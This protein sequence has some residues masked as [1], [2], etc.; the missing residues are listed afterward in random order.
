MDDKAFKANLG[1]RLLAI[2]EMLK[3]SQRKFAALLGVAKSTYKRYERDEAL[4]DLKFLALVCSKCSV[5]AAWLLLGEGRMQGDADPLRSRVVY[6]DTVIYL[7]TDLLRQ[8][9]IK[10]QADPDNILKVA[11][12]RFE[13]EQEE[14]VGRINHELRAVV[15]ALEEIKRNCEPLMTADN[16]AGRLFEIAESAIRGVTLQEK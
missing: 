11:R 4:P 7:I 1:E 5:N 16:M 9:K 15:Q 10:W 3:V 12:E 2:R 13:V 6:I 14:E 8:A